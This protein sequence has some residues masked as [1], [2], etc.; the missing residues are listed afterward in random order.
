MTRTTGAALIGL[1]I[2]MSGCG[3]ERGG[4][5]GSTQAPKPISDRVWDE[6]Q[7]LRLAGIETNDD[8]ISYRLT[9]HPECTAAVVMVSANSVETYRSAGDTV[10]TNPDGTAGVKVTAAELQTCLQRFTEALSAVK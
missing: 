6:S 5:S 10:A 7:V 2:V 1:L 9:A 8:G 4:T 3:S